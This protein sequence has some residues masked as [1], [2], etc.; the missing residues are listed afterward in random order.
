LGQLDVKAVVGVVAFAE[1]AEVAGRGESGR[2]GGCQGS[3][4]G[5]GFFLGILNLLLE[6][7]A[8]EADVFPAEDLVVVGDTWS[9]GRRKAGV[10]WRRS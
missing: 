9:Q 6:L 2:I 8:F 3:G 4:L 10:K 7:E 1:L 5:Y